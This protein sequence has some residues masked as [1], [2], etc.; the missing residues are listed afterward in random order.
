MKWQPIETAPK[1][2]RPVDLLIDGERWTD[3]YWHDGKWQL[4]WDGRWIET[5]DGATHWMSLP[6]PPE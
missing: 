1:D 6:E 5:D 3:C 4:M 2:D